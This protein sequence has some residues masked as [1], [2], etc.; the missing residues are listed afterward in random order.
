MNKN[1]SYNGA[2]GACYLGY[3]VLAIIINLTPILFMP[4]QK[5]YHI[6]F[7]QLGGLIF[8]NFCVQVVSDLAFGKPADRYGVRI[9]AIL[10]QVCTIL[11]LVIFAFAA[12]LFADVFVGLVIGTVLFSI[13]GGL[14]E[15]LLN[16]IAASI[17]INARKSAAMNLLH[18]FYSW[19][20]IFV[21]I[22]TTLLVH[23]WGDYIWKW[24]ALIWTIV[25]IL[26]LILFSKVKLPPIVREGKVRTPLREIVK[27]KYF[28]LIILAL[29]MGAASEHVMGEWSSTFLERAAKLPK[30]IGDVAGVCLFAAMM[31]IGRVIYYKTGGKHLHQIITIGAILA[32]ASYI[33]IALSHEPLMALASCALCGLSVSIMWPGCIVL[34][35]ERFPD[36]GT[37]MYSLLGASGDIGAAFAPWL[38]G[39]V[40]DVV[41]VQHGADIGLKAG[42]LVV[43]VFPAIMVVAMLLLNKHKNEKEKAAL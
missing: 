29:V 34:A 9:F 5:I 7:S 20:Q 3:V 12:D 14:L 10:A 36:A 24:I 18:S 35:H 43:A 42:M 13:G 33:I 27:S 6:S 11:G 16:P 40:T 19:G 15:L 21:I 38:V 1:T 2:M 23:F 30:I 4:L 39:I 17:P 31:G 8:V 32:C 41:A 28:L 25:P 22:V 37:T 26:T